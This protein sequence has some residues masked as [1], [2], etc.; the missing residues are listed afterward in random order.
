MKADY[1]RTEDSYMLIDSSEVRQVSSKIKAGGAIA[2]SAKAD[3]N[4][5]EV[6]NLAVK[7]VILAQ[8]PKAPSCTLL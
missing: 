2:C 8:C 5:S 3:E 6:I 4:V 1:L 7:T